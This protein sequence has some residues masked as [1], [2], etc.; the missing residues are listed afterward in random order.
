MQPLPSLP[1]LPA[2]AAAA[3][4]Q[5]AGYVAAYGNLTLATLHGAGHHA[6]YFQ[7]RRALQLLRCWL[8]GEE[9]PGGGR[10]TDGPRADGGMQH[11]RPWVAVAGR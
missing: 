10:G 11:G 7:P 5:T 8:A 6:P 2:A 3:R 1:S 9:L 4:V